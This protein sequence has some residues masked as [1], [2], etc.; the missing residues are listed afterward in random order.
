MHG[1]C[2]PK[3][4][5][6]EP[7]DS[8][9][10]ESLFLGRVYGE[11]WELYHFDISIGA[12]KLIKTPNMKFAFSFGHFPRN[13]VEMDR[14]ILPQLLV[15][16]EPHMLELLFTLAFVF[17]VSD[18]GWGLAGVI[19]LSWLIPFVP[20]KWLIAFFERGRI[21]ALVHGLHKGYVTTASKAEN[22]G[23]IIPCVVVMHF[24]NDLLKHGKYT[25]QGHARP[26]MW[27]AMAPPPHPTA[28][29]D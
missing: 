28:I 9:F 2:A 18:H 14:D 12:F 21:T 29:A 7:N 25:G 17:V 24:L 19:C 15:E 3:L 20:G 22:I 23:Y 26:M 4:F 11:I 27:V 16:L 5:E 6:S 8:N 10:T 1:L 13:C